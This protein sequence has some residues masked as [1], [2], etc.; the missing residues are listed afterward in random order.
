M[1]E[2]LEVLLVRVCSQSLLLVDRVGDCR[3]TLEHFF[4]T[5]FMT[6]LRHVLGRDGC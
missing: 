5:V 2:G 4:H 6:L 1:L 3:L